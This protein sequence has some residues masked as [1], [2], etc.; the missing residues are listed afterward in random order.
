M[1]TVADVD[2]TAWVRQSAS[3]ILDGGFP[4]T[5]RRQNLIFEELFDG[6]VLDPLHYNVS[7][8]AP[9]VDETN[10]WMVSTLDRNADSF[11][12]TGF[13]DGGG[14]QVIVTCDTNATPEGDSI[15]IS[16]TTNYNGTFTATNVSGFTFEITDTWVS[17]DVT[18]TGTNATYTPY[19]TEMVIFGLPNAVGEFHDHPTNGDFPGMYATIGEEYW[20]GFSVFLPSGF[21]TDSSPEI[22]AQ[23]HG[24]PD[25][26][27]DFRSPNVALGINGANYTLTIYADSKAITGASGTAPD[28]ARYT[29]AE[30]VTAFTASVAPTINKWTN[31]V[32]HVKWAYDGTGFLTIYQDGVSVYSETNTETC[33]NDDVGPS[34]KMGVYKWPWDGGALTTTDTRLYYHDNIRIGNANATLADV[35][36]D[37]S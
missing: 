15:V 7:G 37:H 28:S 22:I 18:G 23:W 13:A 29:R 4:S 17:D 25:V 36:T 20:Y 3:P 8:N 2:M 10:D 30:N 16:G 33:F 5:A 21:V 6:G 27:E 1:T 34:F 9:I 14:G 35:W 26:G 24:K 31:W 11:S 12:I 32:Y 19:R